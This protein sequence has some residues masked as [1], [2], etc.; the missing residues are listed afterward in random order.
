MQK[1]I[2]RLTSWTLFKVFQQGR[3]SIIFHDTKIITLVYF[4]SRRFERFEVL[5]QLD[6]FCKRVF[7]SFAECEKHDLPKN[8]DWSKKNQ[9]KPYERSD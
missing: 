6:A 5:T 1:R 4:E 3:I 2:K 9:T 7:M 8:L